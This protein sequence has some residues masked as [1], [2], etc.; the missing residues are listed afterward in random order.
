MFPI[1]ARTSNAAGFFDSGA[2]SHRAEWDGFAVPAALEGTEEA[3]T[4]VIR[5]CFRK[6]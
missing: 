2:L 1:S 5:A 6:Q 4:R 3:E